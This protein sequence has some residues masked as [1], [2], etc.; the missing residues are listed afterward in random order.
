MAYIDPDAIIERVRELCTE[1]AGTLRQIALNRFSGGAY[2][3]L[4]DDELSRRAAST[5]RIDVRFL[6]QERADISPPITGNKLIYR[7]QLSVVITRHMHIEEKLTD[8]TR[9]TARGLAWQ[10]GDVLRQALCTPGNMAATEEAED[11]GVISNALRYEGSDT[12]R[13]Q[14]VDDQAGL[15]ETEHRFSG[16][17]LATV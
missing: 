9:D 14:L 16:Y 15:I 6:S 2:E 10:D 7:F 5:P 13:F 12:T 3:G 1:N 4:T 11:T 8:A 17:A